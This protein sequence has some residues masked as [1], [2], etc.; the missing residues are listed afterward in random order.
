MYFLSLLQLYCLHFYP[1]YSKFVG[2]LPVISW[3][4]KKIVGSRNVVIV[5]MIFTLIICFATIYLVTHITL[6]YLYGYFSRFFFRKKRKNN[7]KRTVK[8][9]K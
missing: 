3:I 5:L 6:I 9:G 8:N 2:D 7:S 1:N 4:I